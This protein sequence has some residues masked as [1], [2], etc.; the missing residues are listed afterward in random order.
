MGVSLVNQFLYLGPNTVEHGQDDHRTDETDGDAVDG[1]LE[2][3]DVVGFVLEP[4]R[5]GMG[6]T[7]A[8]QRGHPEEEHQLPEL[9]GGPD[10]PHLHRV[11]E[12]GRE[13]EAAADGAQNGLQLTPPGARATVPSTPLP[14]P[15]DR[16]RIAPSL[17][18]DF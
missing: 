14:P 4:T 5:S 8:D 2:A 18:G 15:A 10:P 16:I 17:M 12:R 11:E 1:L 13:D 7:E 6:Q 9:G 3:G